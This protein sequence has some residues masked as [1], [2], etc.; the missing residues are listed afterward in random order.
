MKEII[1]V[2]RVPGILAYRNKTTVGWRSLANRSE[3]VLLKSFKTLRRTDNKQVWSV[4][5]FYI[6]RKEGRNEVIRGLLR[7]AI[8]YAKTQAQRLLRVIQSTH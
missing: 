2:G 5:C 4:V 1:Y 3:F 6:H 7:K 8:E